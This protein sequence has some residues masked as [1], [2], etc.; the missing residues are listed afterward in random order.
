VLAG[1]N[2]DIVVEGTTYHIQSEDRGVGSA[3]L[4]SLIY[5]GGRILDQVRTSYEHLVND[6]AVDSRQLTAMLQAQHRDVVRRVRHGAFAP[7]GKRTLADLIPFGRSLVEELARLIESDPEVELLRIVWKPARF[8]PTVRGRV[9][10]RLFRHDSPVEGA[11]VTMRAIADDGSPLTLL[12]G[13]TDVDGS[14]VV[15][16]DRE[17]GGLNSLIIRAERGPGGGRL[18]VPLK[19]PR[20]SVR[21]EQVGSVSGGS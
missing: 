2:E 15:E 6:G 21:G 4:E 17:W 19:A 8:S 7:E 3:V 12:E 14:L 10:V 20:A 9:H 13:E 16:L 5:S 1:F 18:R 11:L